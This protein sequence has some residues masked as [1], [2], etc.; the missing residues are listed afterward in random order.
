M[1]DSWREVSERLERRDKEIQRRILALPGSQRNL[2][3][4]VKAG[5]SEAR[6]LKL[7]CFAVNEKGSWRKP[8]RRKKRE[9]ESIADQLAP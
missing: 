7:L 6:I 9:L 3:A 4:L 8:L 1:T 2:K 5:A